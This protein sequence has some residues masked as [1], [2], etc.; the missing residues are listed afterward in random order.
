MNSLNDLKLVKCRNIT[1]IKYLKNIK[2]INLSYTNIED[3]SILTNVSKLEC[4]GCLRLKIVFGLKN[5]IYLDISNNFNLKLNIEDSS[6]LEYLLYS[7]SNIY[8]NSIF[9][10]NISSFKNISNINISNC[11]NIIDISILSN[12][13]ELN[14]SKCYNIKDISSLKNVKSLNICYCYGIEDITSLKNIKYLYAVGCINISKIPKFSKNLN[15]I[16]LSTGYLIDCRNF[17]D[18]I[19]LKKFNLSNSLFVENL[20]SISYLLN[21]K[22]FQNRLVKVNLSNCTNL[23]DVSS[24]SNITKLNLSHCSEVRDVNCLKNVKYL[25]LSNCIKIKDVSMLG[26]VFKLNLSHTK[27]SDVSKLG[28]NNILNLIC[29]NNIKDVS[30]LEC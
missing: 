10:N 3:V 30:N 16:Y 11:N 2:I 25:N 22:S 19:N 26:N 27:I 12:V 5:I 13:K 6:K 20:S 21:K 17:I 8:S 9:N 4:R 18:C 7:S 28:N 1:D 14:I 15:V 24:L 23:I 29:C